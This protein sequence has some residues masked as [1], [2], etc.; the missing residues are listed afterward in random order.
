VLEEL[1]LPIPRPPLV[2]WLAVELLQRLRDPLL[3]S[4][5]ASFFVEAAAA[6]IQAQLVERIDE[7]LIAAIF[8]VILRDESRHVALG[9]EVVSFLLTDPDQRRGWK[10][11]RKRVYRR[12]L[13]GYS[14]VTL[15]QYGPVARLFGIDTKK[16]LAHAIE[17][18]DAA[19]TL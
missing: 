16:A 2:T 13:Y 6:Q 1:R 10:R 9:R 11:I 15:A 3:S 17:R 19:M 18:V 8:R 12:N 14:A 5:S 7:P 4:L